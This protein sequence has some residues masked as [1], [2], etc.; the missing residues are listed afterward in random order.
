MFEPAI[1]FGEDTADNIVSVKEAVQP[2]ERRVG[3]G[4]P[5]GAHRRHGHEDKL[6]F[7]TDRAPPR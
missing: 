2:R 1:E 6:V 3:L 4:G 7:T 5:R